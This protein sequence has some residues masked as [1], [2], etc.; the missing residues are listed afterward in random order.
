MPRAM[1]PHRRPPAA[2][3]HAFLQL[4]EGKQKPSNGRWLFMTIITAIVSGFEV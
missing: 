3:Q 2:Y 4:H 1:T